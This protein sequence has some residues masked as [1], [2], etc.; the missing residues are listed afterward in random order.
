LNTTQALTLA[1]N[2]PVHCALHAS[3]DPHQPGAREEQEYLI[4]DS[5]SV[6]QLL[7]HRASH[8]VWLKAGRTL[9][10]GVSWFEWGVVSCILHSCM[11]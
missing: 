11:I 4:T 7:E 5:D 2:I 3:H 10:H 9:D 6:V 1:A 8:S